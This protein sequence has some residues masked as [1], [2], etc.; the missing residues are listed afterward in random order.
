MALALGMAGAGAAETFPAFES[1]TLANLPVTSGIFSGAKLTMV[2]LWATWC[3]PC[4]GEMPDLGKLGRAMPEGSQLVG[5]LLDATVEDAEVIATA[6]DIVGKAQ[7]NFTQILL[8]E[9]MEAYM[10][11]NV[12]AI[13]TTIFVNSKGEIVGVPLVGSR[14]ESAYRMEL[15]QL[16]KNMP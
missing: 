7:A 9:E 3:P 4:V 5:I 15:E 6:Q 16:L 12:Q 2:N 14:S 8:S 1:R 11:A 13:P 10:E